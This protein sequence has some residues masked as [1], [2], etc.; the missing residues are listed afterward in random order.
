MG[1]CGMNKLSASKQDVSVLRKNLLKDK[2]LHR[3][4]HFAMATVYELFIYHN[5]ALYAK[6]AVTEIFIEIDRLEAL[7]SKFIENSEIS[8][9][10]SL[11][12]FIS[13]YVRFI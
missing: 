12:A 2:N 13:S 10:N 8:K 3:F 11:R 5:D 9:I 6:R 7:L 1:T 4:S